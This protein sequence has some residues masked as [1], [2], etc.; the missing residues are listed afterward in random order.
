[1]KKTREEKILTFLFIL[2]SVILIAV[3]VFGFI[4]WTGW[5]SLTNW[6]DVIPISPL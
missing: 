6:K 1:M 2:P 5:V 4:A 3:F